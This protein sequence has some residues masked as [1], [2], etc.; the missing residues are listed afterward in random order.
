[1]GMA[2]FQDAGRIKPLPLR[3]AGAAAYCAQR[4]RYLSLLF[5]SYVVCNPL[6]RR[7]GMGVSLSILQA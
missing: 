3:M 1:M 6:K 4:E 7:K 5:F 2:R